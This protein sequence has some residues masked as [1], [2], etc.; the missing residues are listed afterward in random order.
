MVLFRFG[1]HR[2]THPDICVVECPVKPKS[3]GNSVGNQKYSNASEGRR[4]GSTLG[5]LNPPLQ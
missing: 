3:E 4:P 1:S 2:L 5:V